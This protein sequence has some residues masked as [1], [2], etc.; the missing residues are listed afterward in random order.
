MEVQNALQELGFYQGAIDGSVGPETRA[1]IRA[2]QSEN[3]LSVTGRIDTALLRLL[4]VG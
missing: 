2:Y 1:A 3:G 4:E